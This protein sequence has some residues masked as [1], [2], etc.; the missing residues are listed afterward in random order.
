MFEMKDSC[1]YKECKLN[2]ENINAYSLSMY[3]GDN[4]GTY[5]YYIFTHTT[6]THTHIY[7]HKQCSV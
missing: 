1:R 3:S 7:L 6:H 4:K 5:I 2:Y